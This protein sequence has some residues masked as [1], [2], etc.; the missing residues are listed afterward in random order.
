MD[1]NKSN[2]KEE[3][4]EEKEDEAEEEKVQSC[5]RNEVWVSERGW[6]WSPDNRSS[7]LANRVGFWN[8]MLYITQYFS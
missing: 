8:V 1:D 6:V 2:R 7:M 5:S 3:K 4:E